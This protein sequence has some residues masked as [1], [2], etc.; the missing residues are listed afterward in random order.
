MKKY[1]YF[2]LMA[3]A[4]MFS[5]TS[6]KTDKPTTPPSPGDI[7]FFKFTPQIVESQRLAAQLEVYDTAM[8]YYVEQMPIWKFEQN[9][10]K[11][12]VHETFDKA[13]F[14]YLEEL[15]GGQYTWQQLMIGSFKKGNMIVDTRET[16][17]VNSLWW[18]QEYVL[19][20]Y[21]VNYETAEQITPTYTIH[22]NTPAPKKSDMTFDVQITEKTPDGVVGKIIPSNKDEKYFLAFQTKKY[23]ETYMTKAENGELVDGHPAS[24]Y[25]IWDIVDSFGNDVT[26]ATGDFEITKETVL[27]R[28]NVKSTNKYYLII[29]GFDGGCTTKVEYIPMF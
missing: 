21:G 27:T 8:Y 19:Y 4:I 10:G 1:F 7:E 11:E 28:V 5:A 9:G 17:G 3:I 25:P 14:Q 2:S 29:C 18:D 15:Y 13:Y 23:C 22:M 12:G 20:C 6:C 16:L 26:Y 24:E